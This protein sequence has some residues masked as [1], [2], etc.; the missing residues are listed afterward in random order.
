MKEAPAE[1]HQTSKMELFEYSIMNKSEYVKVLNLER[2]LNR[3][4]DA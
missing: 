2:M 1:L 3:C 4:R